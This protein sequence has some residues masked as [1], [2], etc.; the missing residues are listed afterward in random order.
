MALKQ[1]TCGVTPKGLYVLSEDYTYR[2]GGQDITVLEG[3]VWDGASAPI[4]SSVR[5]DGLIRAA[6]LIHDYLYRN[7][8]K[9][10]S[11]L[12]F[13]RKGA[14]KLFHR[15]MLEAKMSRW[16]AGKAYWAVR[17]FGWWAWNKH[18]LAKLQAGEPIK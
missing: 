16:K 6:A 12:S 15:I 4:R 2:F 1:P 9:A 17:G 14:D 3:F 11:T 13:S 10:T 5:K 7:L 18:M 8:G